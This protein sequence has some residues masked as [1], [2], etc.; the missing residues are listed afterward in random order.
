MSI[1]EFSMSEGA[2]AAQPTPTT[3]TKKTPPKR[4]AIA[5]SDSTLQ[6]EPR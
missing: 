5:K 3:G 4:Q 6:P 2:I 1:G